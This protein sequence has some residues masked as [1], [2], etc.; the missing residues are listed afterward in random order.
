MVIGENA[1]FMDAELLAGKTYYVLVTPRPGLWK[2]R[3]SLRPIHEEELGTDDFDEWYDA[4]RWVEKTAES[5][6]W[7]F[8]NMD[9]IREKQAAY[10]AKW[11]DKPLAERPKLYPQD[12]Q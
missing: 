1:D 11:A 10:L 9:S 6:Q 3:F 4:S 7:A 8:E 5:D 12:G 2:A